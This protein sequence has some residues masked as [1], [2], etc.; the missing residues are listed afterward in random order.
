MIRR[1]ALFPNSTLRT[2]LF[3][4]YAVL[5]LVVVVLASGASLGLFARRLTQ[6][7]HTEMIDQATS[8]ANVVAA[9][10]DDT[11]PISPSMLARLV[12]ADPR[13]RGRSRPLLI[14]DA[15][16]RA[17]FALYPPPPMPRQR[18]DRSEVRS[19]APGNEPSP[20]DIEPSAPRDQP[21]AAGGRR[22]AGA[23]L[24]GSAWLGPPR[25]AGDARLKPLAPDWLGRPAIGEVTVPPGMR[26]LYV[27]VP[28]SATLDLAGADPAWLAQP[29]DPP[30]YLAYARPRAEVHGLWTPLV[31]STLLVGSLALALASGLAYLLARSI[32]RPLEGV[33]QASERVA[34]GDYAVRVPAGGADE[35]GRLATAFNRMAEE[36]GEAHRRQQEFVVN[37]SHDLRTPLTAIR[38]FARALADGTARTDPQRRRAIDAIE[39]AGGRMADLVETLIDL[40]HL[41][42]HKGGMRQ[43][44]VPVAALLARVVSDHR[45]I[46][47]RRAVGL[48]VDAPADLVAWAD[49]AWMARALG[50]LV[51]NAVQHS[52]AGG[53]VR[54]S[55]GP[56][57]D[58]MVEI[59]V[60]DHGGGIAPADLPRVFDRFY[61]GDRARSTSGSGLGLSIAREI[62]EGHGGTI[63]IASTPGVT[64]SV[65]VR[66]PVPPPADLPLARDDGDH[67]AAPDAVEEP[68]HRREEKSQARQVQNA[69]DRPDPPGSNG[70]QPALQAED[71]RE[72]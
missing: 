44:A 26:L 48:S 29:P 72:V 5:A 53:D 27:T 23:S 3:A 22:P 36:V 28:L 8:L 56:A 60:I 37:V 46:A 63:A 65:T 35:L 1:F 64:T 69:H 34:A 59:R 55:A 12:Y 9:V 40:A 49:P 18:R 51:D 58:A 38:G 31:P 41:E 71:E 11:R 42:A 15:A 21:M 19:S 32:T 45:P 50:N 39:N 54:L 24:P 14:V 52:P 10:Q 62:V 6:A 57:S 16:G 61:R 4:S 2:R 43:Q 20:P 47:E 13:M 70:P 68:E 17:I 67:A 33:T 25:F 7:A 30:L 66:L